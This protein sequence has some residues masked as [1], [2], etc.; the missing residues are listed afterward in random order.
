MRDAPERMRRRRQQE[1]EVQAEKKCVSRGRWQASGEEARCCVCRRHMPPTMP[2]RHPLRRVCSMRVTGAIQSATRRF[3][4]ILAE[5]RRHGVIAR[6]T[7]VVWVRHSIKYRKNRN[8]L[9][10]YYW[11]LHA[12]GHA[13][14]SVVPPRVMSPP[15]QCK[16]RESPGRSRIIGV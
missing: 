13:A 10:E 6:S 9:D 1:A 2:R 16:S 5:R 12:T 3:A 11:W 14:G 4:D 7:P 8:T 15:A